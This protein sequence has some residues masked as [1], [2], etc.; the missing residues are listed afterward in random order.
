MKKRALAI[1]NGLLLGSLTS[2]DLLLIV[3]H[4]LTNDGW[5]LIG[6]ALF[7]FAVY[8]S[9]RIFPHFTVFVIYE[10]SRKVYRHSDNVSVPAFDEAKKTFEKRL[11]YILMIVNLLMLLVMLTIIVECI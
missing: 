8:L 11:P 3:N 10:L 5:L 2:V 7:C 9:G 6:L 1:A 4:G